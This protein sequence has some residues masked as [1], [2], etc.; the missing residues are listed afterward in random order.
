MNMPKMNPYMTDSDKMGFIYSVH[1]Y[2]GYEGLFVTKKEYNNCGHFG[3]YN[4]V[5][6]PIEKASEFDM[7]YIN[8]LLK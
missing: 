6:F 4:F 3:G 1:T 7:K 5:N 8:A 2:E